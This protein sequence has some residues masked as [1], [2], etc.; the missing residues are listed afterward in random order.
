MLILIMESKT[1]A[2][3]M[4][5][6]ILLLSLN[7]T[8]A[9]LVDYKEELTVTKYYKDDGVLV[10]R[11]IYADYDNNDRFST[12]N[13]RHGYSYR[14]SRDYWEDHHNTLVKNLVNVIVI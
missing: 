7:F 8:S 5:V 12:Y 6:A 10:A 11:K 9:K 4:L 13:Y 3:L 1:L 2:G 14:T